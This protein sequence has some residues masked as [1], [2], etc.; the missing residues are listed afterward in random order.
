MH[1]CDADPHLP[2]TVFAFASKICIAYSAYLAYIFHML[3]LHMPHIYLIYSIFIFI[4]NVY[5]AY[6]P[7]MPPH[8]S[9]DKKPK[10]PRTKPDSQ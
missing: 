1:L 5:A 4:H 2:D 7:M 10:G 9:C 6:T 3:H 8:I